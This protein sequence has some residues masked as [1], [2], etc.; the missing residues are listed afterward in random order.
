MTK[1]D[2]YWVLIPE[3]NTYTLTERL[4][5]LL[6]Q[7]MR[8]VHSA[9]LNKKN[10]IF[11]KV[12][13]SDIINQISILES[14]RLYTDW[15][16]YGAVSSIEQPPLDG[17]KISLLVCF[18]A[19]KKL[20]KKQEE[21]W[22]EVYSDGIRRWFQTIRYSQK[23]AE[24]MSANEQ[25]TKA[26]EQHIQ[27]LANNKLTLEAHCQRTWLFVRDI[28]RHYHE[29][30]KSRNNLFEK[31]GLTPQ[32][33]FIASTGIGGYGQNPAAVLCADFLSIDVPHE[34]ISYLQAQEFLNPTYEYGVAFERGTAI[35]TS[36]GTTFFISGTA[37]IDKYGH[38][39]YQ[40]KIIQQT[41]RLFLNIEKL[42][43]N[44]G[45]CLSDIQ[46]MIV[47]VRDFSDYPLVDEYIRK[48]CPNVPCI[49]TEARVCRP[50]WLIEVECIAFSNK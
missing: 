48:H 46:W 15:L 40:G 42:L 25:T 8:Q 13:F 19:D 32:T 27:L 11:T 7:L 6:E 39:L 36:N 43:E 24:S 45:G 4:D 29:V 16:K 22:V 3:S 14:H 34:A 49:I 35:Q 37:S 9:G 1:N 33:H 26:F 2:I 17:S 47:Y 30:V 10:L 31:E 44:K 20:T 28:D 50:E 23:E 5:N 41:E 38:C 12:F 21:N 18:N